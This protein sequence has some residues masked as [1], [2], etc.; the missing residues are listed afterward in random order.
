MLKN[1]NIQETVTVVDPNQNDYEQSYLF[2][3]FWAY[4]SFLETTERIKLE[5]FVRKFIFDLDHYTN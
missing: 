1:D 4:G 5:E 2:S 3:L